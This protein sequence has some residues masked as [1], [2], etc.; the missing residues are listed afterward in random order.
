MLLSSKSLQ[1]QTITVFSCGLT[2]FVFGL[3]FGWVAPALDHLSSTSSTFPITEDE[4]SWVASMYFALEVISSIA[5]GFFSGFVG[6]KLMITIGTF[7]QASSWVILIVAKSA[8]MV[9]LSR[10]ILGIAAGLFDIT[11]SIYLGEITTP[12]ERGIFGSMMIVLVIGGE[13]IEFFLSLF[14]SYA[15]LSIIPLILSLVSL[16]MCFVMVETPQFLFTRGKKTQALNNLAWLRGQDDVNKVQLEFDEMKNY[17][18]GVQQKKHGLWDVFKSPGVSRV[19]VMCVIIFVLA[20]FTGYMVIISYQA[21]VLDQ[22][23]DIPKGRYL[24]LIF[25]VSTFIFVLVNICFIETLGRR[26]LLLVGFVSCAVVQI[27]TAFLMYCQEH[28]TLD[29]TWIPKI[30][31]VLFNLYGIIFIMCIFP[32][33][34]VLRSELFPHELKTIGSVSATVSNAFAEFLVTKFFVF[35]WYRYGLYANFTFYAI[36]SIVS[37]VYVYFLVPETKGKSLVQIQ[38]ELAM[39][40]T[41]NSRNLSSATNILSSSE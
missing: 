15:Y 14:V 32:T 10:A 24:T 18:E 9:V 22:Y 29:T 23:D 12:S 39:K 41:K 11:W 28:N 26:T 7:L 3:G 20:Q 13:M 27:L 21:V 36:V 37:I 4:L 19:F 16:T 6:R 17:I 31:V 8:T 33:I 34:F 35:V 1:R 40:S 30:I 5:A 25:G 38:N 2:C